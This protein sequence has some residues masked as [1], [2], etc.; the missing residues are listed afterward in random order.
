MMTRNINTLSHTY[1]SLTVKAAT[2]FLLSIQ[3]YSSH[4]YDYM[5]MTIWLFNLI[6]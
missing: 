2:K 1:I 3:L 6:I 5:Y 4:V